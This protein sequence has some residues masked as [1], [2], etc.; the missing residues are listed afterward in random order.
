M[1]VA[2]RITTL[3]DNESCVAGLTPLWGFA[4]LI[5]TSTARVLFDTGSNGRVLLRNM[6]ALGIADKALD[7]LFLSHAHWDHIGGLDSV[8]ELNPGITVALHQGFSVHLIND[9]RGLCGEVIV[10]GPEPRELAPGVFSTGRLDGPPPEHGMLLDLGGVT[11]AITGCAH[12]GVERIVA[13]GVALLEKPIHWAVGGFHLLSADRLGID[14]SVARLQAL[15]VTDV[16]PTHCTG[17]AAQE[18]FRAAYG[19]HCHAGGVGRAFA[20]AAAGR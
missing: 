6:A 7:M 3:F 13:A 5:E 10:V 1:T 16:A 15:G 17:E 4:A 12:P 2:P 8:L 14:H 19:E 9:L 11:A 18:A 20:L